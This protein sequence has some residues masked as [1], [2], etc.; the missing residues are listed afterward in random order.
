MTLG[1]MKDMDVDSEARLKFAELARQLA[2]GHISNDQ[3]EDALPQSA[4]KALNDIWFGGLWPLYDD[5]YEHKLVEKHKLTP[6]G[7]EWVARIVLFLRSGLPYRWPRRT[8]LVSVPVGL[9]S[10]VTLGWFGRFWN[11]RTG[12]DEAVWPFFARDEYEN[13]KKSPV[14]LAGHV[15]QQ[16]APA[17]SARAARSLRG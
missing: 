10:L 2:V 12:G 13:A 15:A 14:Y 8:G 16:R 9:A 7:R 5:F 11:R 1:D 4:E 6:E 17:D 3:F